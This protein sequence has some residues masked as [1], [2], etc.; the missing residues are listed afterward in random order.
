MFVMY[1]RPATFYVENIGIAR[2]EADIL[3]IVM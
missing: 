3:G 2:H 1:V